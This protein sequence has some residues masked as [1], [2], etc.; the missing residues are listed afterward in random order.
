MLAYEYA[1]HNYGLAT[2]IFYAERKDF[3]SANREGLCSL[4]GYLAL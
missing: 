3:L 1:L 4:V 2:Y